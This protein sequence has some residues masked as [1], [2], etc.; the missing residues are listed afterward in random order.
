M[1]VHI[2]FLDHGKGSASHASAY[3]LDELDHLGNVRAGVEV[4]RGDANT[5]NAACT[6]SPHLWKYTSGVIAW[7]VDDNPSDAQ[8]QEVLD[9]FEQ[10]AFAG[11]DPAQYHLFAVLHTDDD[12]SKHIHVLIPR[13]DLNTSKS[14]NIAPPGHE[15]HFD[16]LRD[17]F[18]TKYQWSRPDDLLLMQTTQEPNYVAKL[19]AQAKHILS[20]QD[21]EQLS[22]KQFCKTI[23]NYVKTLLKTQIA[24]NRAN[25]VACLQQIK[26]VKSV[27]PHQNYVSV[28]LTSGKTHRL[29]G[30]FY[31]EQFEIG[32]YSERLRAEA[33]SRST[34]RELAQ[35]LQDAQSLRDDYRAKREAY[36]TKHYAPTRGPSDHHRSK[37]APKRHID[38]NKP[39]IPSGPQNGNSELQSANRSTIN[40]ACEYRPVTAQQSQI[41]HRFVFNFPTATT[42]RHQSASLEYQD[43]PNQFRENHSNSSGAG[44]RSAKREDQHSIRPSTHRDIDPSESQAWTLGDHHL[45]NVDDFNQYLL[46][47]S[48]TQPRKHHPSTTANYSTERQSNQQSNRNFEQPAEI[49]HAD[50]NRPLTE[51]TEQ[52]V[53]A[54]EQVTRRRKFT[55]ESTD[56]FI[57]DHLEY[58]QRRRETITRENQHV[59]IDQRFTTRTHFSIEERD[60]QDRTQQFFTGITAQ[61]SEQSRQSIAKSINTGFESAQL[62]RDCREFSPNLNITYPRTYEYSAKGLRGG[63]LNDF[64]MYGVQKYRRRL[65]DSI[66]ANVEARNNAYR[67][68]RIDYLFEK[69]TEGA[70]DL[71]VK[72]D[73]ATSFILR[74]DNYYPDYN[75]RHKRFSEQ[76]DELCQRKDILGMIK[77]MAKKADN[78]KEYTSRGWRDLQSFDYQKIQKIIR[79][80]EITL[81]YLRCE[82][83]L[84]PQND[85]LKADR[86]TYLKCLDTFEDI[87]TL[88]A[89]R[90][91][92]TPVQDRQR[93]EPEPE[94]KPKP[95]C[96]FDF[97]F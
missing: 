67:L 46:R 14:L 29:K 4:L 95:S 50:R 7:S 94:N 23:D 32:L 60:I 83:I 73:M 2:K 57:K 21:I 54:A 72:P 43:R 65:E 56:Q 75:F 93:S 6:A 85:H 33:E 3:V 36:N 41:Q 24:A 68:G 17:Y 81:H 5:F 18:N 69:V 87:K 64:A 10:H 20:S 47:L 27:K 62:T 15:K 42:S 11:L 51:R 77:C 89:E 26:G 71:R 45:C 84:E 44:Y 12:G 8:I 66:R 38:R 88:I 58:V 74:Y 96:D 55:I 1:N 91:A 80:D 13:L 25:I 70:K 37:I 31:N 16:A 90:L 82:A 22:K 53:N 92:P 63:N 34:P 40:A 48:N 28:T 30:D 19:N 97:D 9:E 49:T 61:I 79:N 76:Q 59:G 78:L 86:Q 52:F 39:F 35:A